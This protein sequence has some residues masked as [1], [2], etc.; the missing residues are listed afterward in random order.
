VGVDIDGGEGSGW[1]VIEVTQR[2]TQT[3]E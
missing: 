2:D 3:T 1:G